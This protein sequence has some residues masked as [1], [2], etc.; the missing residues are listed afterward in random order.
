[1]TARA[2]QSKANAQANAHA[3]EKSYHPAMI[4]AAIVMLIFWAIMTFAFDGPGWVHIFLSLGVF[5]LIWGVVARGG[6][7]RRRK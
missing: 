1:M 6:G 3:S 4:P 5:L 2:S 7:T